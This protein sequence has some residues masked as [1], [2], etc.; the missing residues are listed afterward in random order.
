MK[1]KKIS[2]FSIVALLLFTLTT[3]AQSVEIRHEGNVV[4]NNETIEFN[5]PLNEEDNYSYYFDVANISQE[6]IF[7]QIIKDDLTTH[8][9]IES[10]FC[11]SETCLPGDS[12][13]V[14]EIEVGGSLTGMNG[15]KINY[16]IFRH[17]AAQLST[18]YH[19]YVND[20][21]ACT[22]TLNAN[23]GNSSITENNM[24][25][26]VHAYP[27]PATENVVIEYAIP[28]QTEEYKLVIR[29]LLGQVQ[30][31]QTINNA[32]N[33]E[34]ISVSDFTPGIYMY[35][36]ESATTGARIIV[37]KMIVE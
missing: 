12:S 15:L 19:I 11:F 9:D 10:S 6:V 35:S 18:V 3:L 8:Q 30:Y 2:L 1:M 27:N 17:V 21:I 25:V 14:C 22:F 29:N 24:D 34:V 32:S 13:T 16:D 23:F 20:A 4:A 5:I 36:I 31:E 28:D 26:A 37:K 7:V 33:K